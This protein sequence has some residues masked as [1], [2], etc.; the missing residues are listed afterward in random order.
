METN[1]ISASL[2]SSPICKYGHR[3][4]LGNGNLNLYTGLHTM[5]TPTGALWKSTY[6]GAAAGLPSEQ[7]R[8]PQAFPPSLAPG[9]AANELSE[10]EGERSG[11]FFSSA[12]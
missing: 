11:S 9:V 4:M 7:L 8:P 10:H 3:L 2:H 5:K 1:S 6:A 12:E